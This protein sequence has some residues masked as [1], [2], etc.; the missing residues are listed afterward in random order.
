MKEGEFYM[1]ELGTIIELA[2]AGYKA[3]DILAL[4]KQGFNKE[5][6]TELLA[7]DPEP[8]P[9]T[10]TNDKN[11]TSEVPKEPSKSIPDEPADNKSS[12]PAIIEMEK[13]KAEL[14]KEKEKVAALQK[15]N[16]QTNNNDLEDEDPT[17]HITD[18]ISSIM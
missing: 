13:L 14:Q 1:L 9:E 6:L 18:L 3:G 7:A 10:P 8:E 16:R 2:K 15:Q 11:P 12:N 17:K 5:V 4:N